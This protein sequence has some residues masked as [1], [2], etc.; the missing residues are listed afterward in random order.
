MYKR[1]AY[2]ETKLNSDFL[3]LQELSIINGLDYESLNTTETVSKS[4]LINYLVNIVS[5]EGADA[6]YN[7][8]I[9]KKAESLGLIVSADS[10][11]DNQILSADEAVAMS[12]RV[13][14]YDAVAVESG[15]PQ[16][17]YNIAY[18]ENLLKGLEL[19]GNVTY[20]QMIKLLRN[21]IEARCV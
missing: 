7:K 21:L 16:G 15:Y 12:V 3:L 13:L 4:T 19:K 9:L 20:A 2:D 1:Q 17:Y 8:E 6:D 18:R 10:V 5:N 14:G 11:N